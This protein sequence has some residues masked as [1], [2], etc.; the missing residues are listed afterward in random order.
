[1][2]IGVTPLLYQS[3][4]VEDLCLIVLFMLWSKCLKLCA[5]LHMLFLLAVFCFCPS[6]SKTYNPISPLYNPQSK[7][8]G[9]YRKRY[10]L[11]GNHKKEN[12]I[13]V[14]RSHIIYKAA[15]LYTY[16]IIWKPLPFSF[17]HLIL[18][19]LIK[20]AVFSKTSDVH[21]IKA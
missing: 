15:K 14:S 17:P 3:I 8:I 5:I 4:I 10:F 20:P 16:C 18:Q 19:L 9:K 6:T 2:D 13:P 7:N 12:F 11:P 1:M 21:N